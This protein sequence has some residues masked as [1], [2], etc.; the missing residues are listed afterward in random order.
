MWRVSPPPSSGKQP[1]SAI[2]SSYETDWLDPV[3]L[4]I[5]FQ[6]YYTDAYQLRKVEVVLVAIIVITIIMLEFV[7][8]ELL[9]LLL[10]LLLIIIIIIIII[11]S[12][13]S[14]LLEYI[15]Q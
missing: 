6:I 3:G 7:M 15:V 8:L 14:F 13:N 10:L 5:P 9:S 2:K 11:I 1:K 4:P 12:Y